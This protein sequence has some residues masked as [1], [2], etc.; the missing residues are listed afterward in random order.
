MRTDGVL[1]RSAL[2]W[3]NQG[4]LTSLCPNGS[5]WVWEGLGECAQDARDMA[6]VYLGLLS[7]V[8]FM[9]SSIP[10]YY[11]SC[12]TGNMDR[13]LSIW[14]LLLWLGG[15]SCNLLGSFLADQLPLQTYTA[16]YY[17][18]ADLIMLA[19]Y[20]YYKMRNRMAEN[21][22]VLYVVGVTCILGFTTS[23]THLPGLGT[24]Q[25]MVPSGFRSR[26]LLSTSDHIKEFTT[27]EIIGFC[28]GSIS[29]V[30]YLCSR[31]PQIYTNFKRK[32]TEGVS[33]F[34]FAL[35]ILGNSTYGL[36]VLLKNPET[37]QGERSYLIHH[38]PWLIGS[39][40][41]LSLDLIITIQFIIYRKSQVEVNSSCSET[42]PL[43][44]S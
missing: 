43:I 24:Q 17:V 23:L 21:R 18:F 39:L 9:I 25:E 20:L 10:Q 38:L 16:I 34:L 40:G 12:K 26:G 11:S 7:I 44:Y 13:A 1:T 15:D 2:G 19:M 22:R 3:S 36:S 42:A 8:C 14:F 5:Q 32:S 28:I 41:T 33:Y 29:S 30:L 6:S 35:V 37:G 4:N 27:K 31:L